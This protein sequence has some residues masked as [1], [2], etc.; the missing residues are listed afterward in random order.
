MPPPY[1]RIAS[2]AVDETSILIFVSLFFLVII[3]LAL[4]LVYPKFF[5]KITAGI[6]IPPTEGPSLI[7]QVAELK[8]EIYDLKAHIQRSVEKQPASENTNDDAAIV[9]LEAALDAEIAA[10][11]HES[12]A[13]ITLAELIKIRREIED[14][15]LSREAIADL[16]LSVD[17]EIE[18]SSKVKRYLMNLFITFNLLLMINFAAY[19]VFVQKELPALTQQVILGL[20]VSIAIFIV[21]VYR[22]SNARVLILLAV[23]EDSKR[24][25]DGLRFLG[26]KPPSTEVNE[27]DVAILKALLVNRTERE[28]GAEH[29]YELVL[30]G[31]S[32]SNI[33]LRGGKVESKKEDKRD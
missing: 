23:K 15:H 28:R 22:V 17:Q 18:S 2:T 8:S 26:A 29:P 13:E 7:R 21:Y 14:Q 20:Y 16:E 24:Y 10:R 6:F 3:F 5:N 4:R 11:I 32:N 27:N 12:K 1:Q 30:K 31:V 19:S 9:D 25:F 33:L